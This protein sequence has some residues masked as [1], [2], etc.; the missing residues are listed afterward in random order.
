VKT[1]N[2]GGTKFALFLENGAKKKI[3]YCDITLACLR[4][5]NAF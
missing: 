5:L 4:A 1:L 2:D 3:P